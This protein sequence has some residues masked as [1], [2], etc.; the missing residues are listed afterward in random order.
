MTSRCALVAVRMDSPIISKILYNAK[1]GLIDLQADTGMFLRPDH[2]KPQGF[3]E[4]LI[5]VGGH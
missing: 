1:E 5:S 4:Y 2:N 3:C